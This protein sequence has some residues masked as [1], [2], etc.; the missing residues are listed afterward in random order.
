VKVGYSPFGI[1]KPENP[2]G[3]KGLNQYEELYA[4]PK[5]WAQQ[6]LARLHLAAAVLEN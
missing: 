3:I 5:L 6:R 2:P 1:W 4:D